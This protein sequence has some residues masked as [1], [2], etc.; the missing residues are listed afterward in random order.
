MITTVLFDLDET[1]FDFHKAE[2]IALSKTLTQLGV[3]ASQENIALYST[4]N[5]KHWEMLEEGRI[6]RAQVLLGRFDELFAT[7]G[8]D[9]QSIQAQKIYEHQLGIGHY[10]IPGAPELLQELKDRYALY[11]VS[12]GTASVQEGRIK[13]SGISPLFREIF[14]SQK[15]GYNK[16]R[17]EFF[18]YCFARIPDFSKEKTIIIGDSLTSDVRGGNNAGIRTC[19]FNPRGN[20]RID[21]IHIDYEVQK[22]E[23]IPALLEEI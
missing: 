21:G 19:W 13:S 7:L 10:F 9:C 3:E 15:V 20:E 2:A 8:A 6:T 4:I 23:Q 16:P 18:D 22:L 11:L 12:N 17:K 1:L 14:I 5:K